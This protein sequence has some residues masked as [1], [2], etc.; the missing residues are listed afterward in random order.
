MHMKTVAFVPAKGTSKRI[1]NKNLQILDGEHL[2]KRKLR[3]LVECTE[4]DEVW[5]D[6][7]SEEIHALASDLPVKHHHR[8]PALA[9]NATDGHEMFHNET[10]ITDADIVVQAL[11]TAPFIDSDLM[12]RALRELKD[13]D[14][15]SLVTVTENK[16]YLW[17]NGKPTYGDRIPNSVDLPSHIVETMS[18][19]A[20]KTGNKAH[21]KRYTDEAILYKI[22]EV[23]AIDINNQKDL[24]LARLVCAGHRSKKMQQHNMLSKTFSSCLLS[25]I[26]KEHGIEHFL[27]PKLRLQN[28]GCFLGYAKTLKLKALEPDQRDPS[29]KDWEGIFDALG[30][31]E[32]IQPG[33]VI[34]VSNDVPDKA[35]FGDLNA[36]FAYR[37]GAVGVVV[38]GQTRDV[39]RV[40]QLGLPLFAHGRQPDDIRYEGTLESMNMPIEINGVAIKNNDIVFGDSD[41]VLV[42]PSD[43]WPLVLSEAKEAVRK[44]MMVKFEAT[45]GS[46]PFYVLNN[47]GL[48]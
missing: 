23:N 18:F 22:D 7:E 5:I 33:D 20:V 46:D 12:D 39:D 24:E 25:D 21:A 35:Y 43:K 14:K 48:F 38:D 27:G 3:Q 26:C 37:Q 30:S 4:I 36:H 2:F 13:S 6:S 34:V 40:A 32:F 31:Y 28:G 45:F 11:C 47:V 15:T 16:F 44:E 1:S 8:D 17:E 9:S 42:I 41:G 19:Y 10:K 29:K